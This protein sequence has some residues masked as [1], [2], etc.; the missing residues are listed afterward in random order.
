MRP[1]NG[2]KREKEK[3][4]ISLQIFAFVFFKIFTIPIFQINIVIHW[5]SNEFNKK[6]K[7]RYN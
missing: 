2:V 1:N 3:D 4:Q 7:G 5:V 6:L